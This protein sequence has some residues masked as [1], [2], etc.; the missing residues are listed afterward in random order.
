[1]HYWVIV[2]T[3]Y[4]SHA[5]GLGRVAVSRFHRLLMCVDGKCWNIIRTQ[6]LVEGVQDGLPGFSCLFTGHVCKMSR[7]AVHMQTI[8]TLQ[9]QID[10][11]LDTHTHTHTHT[12][13][14][15]AHSWNTSTVSDDSSKI[16]ATSSKCHNDDLKYTLP[17]IQIQ[18]SSSKT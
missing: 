7:T 5:A 15:P 18:K 9:H 13:M 11:S 16:Y 14:H 10:H 1:M 8:D 4:L 12:L 2:N 6:V 3:V 17:H